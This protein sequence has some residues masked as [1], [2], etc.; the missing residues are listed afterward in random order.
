MNTSRHGQLG[1]VSGEGTLSHQSQAPS[2]GDGNVLETSRGDS[3]M[4]S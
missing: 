3:G 2:G 1:Q 4:V